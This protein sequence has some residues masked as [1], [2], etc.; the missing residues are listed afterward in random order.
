MR[1]PF[2]PGV[3]RRG[4]PIK[5]YADPVVSFCELPPCSGWSALWAR[6]PDFHVS[7]SFAGETV[8]AIKGLGVAKT[9]PASRSLMISSGEALFLL[10]GMRS[11]HAQ[12]N[13]GAD[14]R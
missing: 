12:G 8:N 9:I 10:A 3:L 11:N 13:G 5:L 4:S 6:G 7:S 2:P 14:T 1:I